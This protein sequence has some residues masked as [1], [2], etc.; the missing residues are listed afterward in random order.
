MSEKDDSEEGGRHA[1]ARAESRFRDFADLGADWL[2]ELDREF[3]CTFIHTSKAEFEFDAGTV[4]GQDILAL[5]QEYCALPGASRGLKKEVA[6]LEGRRAYAGIERP[7]ILS[8]ERWIRVS[9]KP[10][11]D[12]EGRFDG[13]RLVTRDITEQVMADRRISES[14]ARFRSVFDNAIVGQV[15]IDSDGCILAFNSAAERMFQ[16]RAADAIGRDIAVLISFSDPADDDAPPF[17]L[18]A[19]DNG[20]VGRGREMTGL[21]RDGSRFPIHLGVGDM[22]TNGRQQFIGTITDLTE[23]KAL[24]AQLHQMKKMEA[25]DLFTSGIAHDFNNILGVIQS[26][27]QLLKSGLRDRPDAT[28]R[29]ERALAGVRRGADLTHKL[30][31][32]SV[33]PSGSTSAEALRE[34]LSG[35][36]LPL[37]AEGEAD[38][39]L[40]I[41][42]E[43][44]PWP[45]AAA[46]GDLESALLNLALNAR[47]AM[48]DGGRLW[49][50]VSQA[51]LERGASAGGNPNLAPGEYLRLRITDSGHGMEPDVRSRIFDPF[52][53]TKRGS[54]TGLGLSMVH[55]FAELAGGA[56]DVQSRPGEGTTFT[57]LLPRAAEP[58]S[59]RPPGADERPLP[60]GSE[61]VLIVDDERELVD[62]AERSLIPLGYRTAR[63]TSFDDALAMLA[64][65]E[66]FDLLFTD[67]RLADASGLALMQAYRRAA[68]NG[69]TL[70]TSGNCQ[71]MELRKAGQAG[72]LPA[73]AL[74][75]KPYTERDLA[76]AVREA[77]DTGGGAGTGAPQRPTAPQPVAGTGS[78]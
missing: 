72:P 71:A 22:T 77:L 56:I 35:L 74:L 11:F 68:P 16:W 3:R 17:L 4:I 12:A 62:Y 73:P 76:F 45:I 20:L 13:F 8:T 15:V 69:R 49:I 70:I 41:R 78:S 33:S 67:L 55:R 34:I 25:L 52:F 30:M 14:E 54:G 2:W 53:S 19:R 50:E 21:R 64:G 59:A 66:R 36:E 75:A 47:D 5:Y 9:G 29:L 61:R 57:L 6:A 1:Q 51:L 23:V 24:E 27:I 32:G 37:S 44:D 38:I 63:A 46:A 58:G 40:E 31:G 48:P 28:S 43:D 42:F 10:L 39:A 60:G 7:A 65:E 26:Q 18:T